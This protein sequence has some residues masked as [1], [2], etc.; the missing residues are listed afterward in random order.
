M[1]GEGS[2]EHEGGT[3]LQEDPILGPSEIRGAGVCESGVRWALP[4]HGQRPG[5]GSLQG[6]G[7]STSGHLSPAAWLQGAAAATNS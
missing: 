4:S 7:S 3:R 5:P 6:S 1:W 2:G